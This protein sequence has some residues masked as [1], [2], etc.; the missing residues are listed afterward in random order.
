VDLFKLYSLVVPKAAFLGNA[1]P[2]SQQEANEFPVI[3]AGTSSA[4]ATSA[5]PAPTMKYR[6]F[7]RCSA[8]ILLGSGCCRRGRGAG[9]Y[10]W[11]LICFAFDI[12]GEYGGLARKGRAGIVQQV[13]QI[14][15]FELG[16]QNNH[17]FL[18]SYFLANAS[19]ASESA[20]LTVN[21]SE[22]KPLNLLYL[23]HDSRFGIQ[24]ALCFTKSVDSSE[25]LLKLINFFEDAYMG[26]RKK[27]VVK[28]YSGE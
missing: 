12:D 8:A 17:T 9:G 20:V 22:F 2:R 19:F 10:H 27:L 5:S 21:V 14:E 28:G 24:S 1:D 11:K 23:L 15:G 3:S 18:G 6:G 25:R 16:W 7:R 4:P 26:G 13:Q